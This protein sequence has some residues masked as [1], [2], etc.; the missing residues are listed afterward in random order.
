MRGAVEGHGDA[1][2]AQEAAYPGGAAAGRSGTVHHPGVRAHDRGRD[3]RG[4]RRLPAHLLPL[5][6]GQ[7]GRGLRPAGAGAG[8]LPRR[9][10]RATAARAADGGAAAGGPGGLGRGPGQP[11]VGR[12][13]RPVPAHVPHDRVDARAARRPS[14]PLDRGRGDDGAAAGRAGGRGR[15]DGPPA[16]ARGGGVRRGDKGHRAPVVLGA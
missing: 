16:A 6:R 12:A 1:A 11:G 15:G 5:L 7:G 4:L 14:A 3:S 10:A 13:G 9:P 8:A 2:R